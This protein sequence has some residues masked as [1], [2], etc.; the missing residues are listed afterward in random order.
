M[1]G[2]QKKLTLAR[3]KALK[4]DITEALVEGRMSL[5]GQPVDSVLDDI[6]AGI[7]GDLYPIDVTLDDLL[8]AWSGAPAPVEAQTAAGTAPEQ[9]PAAET[10]A[11]LAAAQQV[12]DAGGT[13]AQVMTAAQTPNT[14]EHAQ[15]ALDRRN[16]V[17]ELEAGIVP[18]PPADEPVSLDMTAVEDWYKLWKQAKAKVDEATEISKIAKEKIGEF[19]DAEGGPDKSKIGFLDGKPVTRRS[20]VIRTNFRKEKLLAD[21]P[22]F[23]GQYEEQTSFYK[24]ELM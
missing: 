24:T 21:H 2:R 10:H 3:R 15:A 11:N 20:F 16:G 19:L 22:E 12:A 17:V 7:K 6:D 8:A 23:S 4:A 14:V 1:G 13:Q 5:G 9:V 18:P